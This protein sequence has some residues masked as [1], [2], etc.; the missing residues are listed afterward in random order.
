LKADDGSKKGVRQS[1]NI[2]KVI[3]DT[4]IDSEIDNSGE[5]L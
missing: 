5:D 2:D 1:L 3:A 4:K